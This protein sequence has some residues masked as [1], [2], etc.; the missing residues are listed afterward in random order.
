MPEDRF[1]DHERESRSGVSSS[2]ANSLTAEVEET[3]ENSVA[4]V[5][6]ATTTESSQPDTNPPSTPQQGN[7]LPERPVE[8]SSRAV[9]KTK[10]SHLFRQVWIL[11]WPIFA[12]ILFV[13]VT[14]VIING[15]SPSWPLSQL[16]PAKG[17][18]LLSIYSKLTDFVL[19]WGTDTMWEMMTWGPLLQKGEE[20][21][22][23]LALTSGIDG[24]LQLIFFRP[25]KKN[26]QETESGEVAGSNNGERANNPLVAAPQTIPPSGNVQSSQETVQSAEKTSRRRSRMNVRAW[27]LIR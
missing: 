19:E 16:S 2:E 15:T 14:P 18:L 5:P 13:V 8:N 26:G 9:D 3:E 6:G 12:V 27:S 24:W 17:T 20:M 21:L 10:K 25:G 4:P 1:L 23:F 7:A 22:T 11:K